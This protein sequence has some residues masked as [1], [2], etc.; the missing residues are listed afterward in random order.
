VSDITPLRDAAIDRILSGDGRASRD[1]RKAAFDNASKHPLVEKVAHSAWEI[2]DEDIAA[3]RAA[4]LSE[5][6]IFELAVCAAIGQ[7]ARQHDNALAALEQ[8]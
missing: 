7:A 8:A 5:D 4:G 2:T 3:A 6:Q 1:D